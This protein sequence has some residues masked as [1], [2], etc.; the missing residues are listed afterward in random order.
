MDVL[1]IGAGVTGAVIASTLAEAGMKVAVMEA[2]N[3]GSGATRRALGVA[4]LDPREA[5]FADTARGLTLLNLDFLNKSAD[6]H[7]CVTCGRIE[8]F[9]R[10]K[11]APLPPATV[12]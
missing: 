5:H 3:V 1:I 9:V 11:T 2:L 6:A 8:W 7:I 10:H 4:T 12:R